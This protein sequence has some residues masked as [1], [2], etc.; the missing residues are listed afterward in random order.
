VVNNTLPD[1]VLVASSFPSSPLPPGLTVEMRYTAK[2]LTDGFSPSLPV[3]EVTLD[4]NGTQTLLYRTYADV[5]GD[6]SG[7]QTFRL[8]LVV[9]ATTPGDYPI[10]ARIN[11][12]GAGRLTESNY[13]NNDAAELILHVAAPNQP[14]VLNPVPGPLAAKVGRTLTFTASATDPNGDPITYRL[15]TGAPAAALIGPSTG[16]FSWTPLCGEG[17]ATYTFPVIAQDSKGATD[18]KTVTVDV[19]LEADLGIIQTFNSPLAVPGETVT[20]T[21]QAVNRGPSCVTGVLVADAFPISL[22]NVQCTCTATAGSSCAAGQTGAIGDSSVVL[23]AGGT[24]T[25]T[26]S[27]RIADTASGLIV[28]TATVTPPASAT[29]PNGTDNSV[30]A[31]LTLR[32]LD[33]GDAPSAALGA[34]WTFPTRL[35]ENGARHG[36]HPEMRLGAA[37]DAEPDGQPSLAASGD[38]AQ[39]ARDE[40]GVLLPAQLV[41]CQTAAI[42]ITASAP[43]FLDAWIDFNTD[44]DWIDTGEHIAASQPLAA[45]G[46]GLSVAVPCAATPG[47]TAFARFR[48]SS[49][50]GLSPS[51][52]ALDGEVEDHAIPIA[53]VLF[54]LTTARAGSGT[55][56][57]TASPG[58]IDCGADCS[59][60]YAT[61]TV[62]TLAASPEAGSAFTG[63]AG[64]GCSGTGLCVVTMIAART[65]TATFDLRPACADPLEAGT[66]NWLARRGPLDDGLSTGWNLEPLG[67]HS[68]VRSWT[69]PAEARVKDQLL[70]SRFPA[71]IGVGPSEL[72][73]WH[74]VSLPA[75]FAGG[76]LEVSVNGGQ[77]WSD[78]LA[79]ASAAIPADPFRVVNNGY[80]SSL[81]SCCS[82]PLAGRDAWSGDSAG[83]QEVAVDLS[84]FAG[85]SVLFRWRLASS[86]A[87]GGGGWWIDDLTVTGATSCPFQAIFSNGFESGNL[88]DWQ[89]IP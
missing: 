56:T 6:I 34:A 3:F 74:R 15:G 83:W 22:G 58:G 40:D 16:I 87:V 8:P 89:G 52:L 11:P 62:V 66:G 31:A 39:G 25:Y 69:V 29:D 55:G 32:G 38:D 78:I 73:F 42:Q 13:A 85:Q 49:T 36:I 12:P 60:D 82:N 1:F 26:V 7:D 21:I 84:D 9:P 86:L 80:T 79:A 10:R 4:L 57:V 65:V 5:R 70:V 71:V 44:G 59:E 20:W 19:G 72:R 28:N 33:F 88:S 24:A 68:P 37:I 23:A 67:S 27:A 48:F 41:P 47:G 63:W 30:S 17:P 54:R 64:A 46:N 50:G 53:Q 43:G 76:V 51:G 61:G 35:V 45:G 2:N 14:P 75:P 77:A 18:T 81:S